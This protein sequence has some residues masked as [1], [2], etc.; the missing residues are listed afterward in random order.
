MGF[1]FF[2]F[3]SRRRHTRCGRDWSSD[4]CSSDLRL[5]LIMTLLEEPSFG[6]HLF[7][8]VSI[9]RLVAIRHHATLLVQ[10]LD[11]LERSG[12]ERATLEFFR[13]VPVLVHVGA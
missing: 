11:G 3:S 7:G 1:L 4:V 10:E 8:R 6:H 2:F 13:V 12:R 9:E 5:D